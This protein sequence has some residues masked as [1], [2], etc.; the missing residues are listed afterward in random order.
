MKINGKEIETLERSFSLREAKEADRTAELSF[1]SEEP[2]QRWFGIEI[3][4]HDSTSVDMSRMENGAPLLLGHNAEDQIGVIVSARIDED[5]IGRAVVKFSRSQRGEE[6]F[7]DVLDG[8]RTKVSVGYQIH[9]M[10]KESEKDGLETYRVTRWQ[11]FEASLVSIPAD[12]TV[13]VGRSADSEEPIEVK[14]TKMEEKKAI[15]PEVEQI[16]VA[17]VRKAAMKEEKTRIREIDAIAGKF[18]MTTD[19][20]SEAIDSGLSVAEFREQVMNVIERKAKEAPV[21]TAIGMTKADVKHYSLFRAITAQAAGNWKDAEYELECSQKVAENLGKDARGFYVPWEVQRDTMGT[22][23]GTGITD[24]G[25]LVGTDHLGGSFID[26]LRA[27]SLSGKLG[28]RFLTGLR[29]NVDIPK[30]TAGATFYWLAEGADV[31]AS[32]ATLASVTLSPKTI[33]GSVAMTRRLLKQS[34]PSVEAIIRQDLI[35]GA[36]L[37]I[38]TA[39]IAGSGAAGQPTGIIN[40]SGVNTVTIADATD[41]SPTF[42]ESVKFETE[43]ATDNA[44]RGSLQWVTT[45]AINGKL[46]TTAID[47]GSGLMVN[48]NGVVNG[49]GMTGSSLVPTQRVIFGN[50]N[51][52]I[53]GMWGVLDIEVDKATLAASGGLVLRV[54]QDVDVA[55]RHAESFAI[56]A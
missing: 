34:D 6:V 4:D 10:V 35:L 30:L 8:I 7:R 31:T 33:A 47:T 15:T 16:D 12:N 24:A 23:S 22:N 11:P 54:F 17:E 29:G 5:K 46:K 53:I 2:Y 19:M 36:A 28:A 18:E 50:F 9:D 32:T 20:K 56:D 21:A 14:E 40:T 49:Y 42:A 3:L 1:S 48:T 44:L 52:V 41:Y 26:A 25:A 43:L 37:A 38:D 27:E 55:I 39:V 13:G 51:D 45:P